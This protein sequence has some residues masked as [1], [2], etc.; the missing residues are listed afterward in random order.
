MVD[1][2]IAALPAQQKPHAPRKGAPPELE[3]FKRDFHPI[4][5]PDAARPALLVALLGRRDL[6]G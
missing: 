5:L 4:A 6:A 2:A 1:H 3:R